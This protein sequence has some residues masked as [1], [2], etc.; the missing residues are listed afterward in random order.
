M[1]PRELDRILK[2]SNLISYQNTADMIMMQEMERLR[3][4]LN[5][6]PFQQL[7]QDMIRQDAMHRLKSLNLGV[8][9]DAHWP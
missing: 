5:L 3:N 8:L 6:S 2:S 4:P 9:D 7:Q 1:S